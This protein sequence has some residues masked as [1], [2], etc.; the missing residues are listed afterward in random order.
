MIYHGDM[1]SIEDSEIKRIF[2]RKREN[3]DKPTTERM[4]SEIELMFTYHK[5][6]RIY[7]KT[8]IILLE[9]AV[10]TGLIYLYFL[11]R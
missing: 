9:A 4:M 5:Y 11:Y 1:R 10:L 2:S 8:A 3:N 7:A 6:S